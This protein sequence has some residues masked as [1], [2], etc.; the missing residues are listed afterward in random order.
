MQTLRNI[1][2]RRLASNTSLPP[3]S[4]FTH[5]PRMRRCLSPVSSCLAFSTGCSDSGSSLIKNFSASTAS[6]TVNRAKEIGLL[7]ATEDLYD[8]VTV[9]MKEPME[10]EVF[11]SLL[12]A[13]MSKWRQQGKKGVWIKLPIQLSSLVEPVVQE[14]FRYHHAESDYLM[15]VHWIPNTPDTLPE[16]ASHRVGIGAFVIN[17]NREVLVVK[18]K[19]GGFRGTGVWK[20]PTGVVH[21]GEDIC[22]AAVREVKEETGIETDFG[23]VLAFRQT[24]QSFFRKSDLFF[25][26]M[27]RPRS[28]DIQKQDSEIQA[29]QWMPIQEYVDQ[30][31]NKEHQAFKYVAEI[32]KNKSEGAYVG[33]SAMPISTSSSAKNTYLYF[34]NLNFNKL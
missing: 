7:N 31:Y 18:E 24:H 27:L 30:A 33:F 21:E 3:S 15:L 19:N 28:F 34:N 6:L 1:K 9:E 20:L 22:A 4:S 14:G 25:I 16:N 5:L 17:N 11:V 10:S 23:E 8:G 2:L 29:A 13:S 12:R 32:C 26:C